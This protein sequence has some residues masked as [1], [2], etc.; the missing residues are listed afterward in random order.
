MINVGK[1]MR[2]DVV[3]ALEGVADID[4]RS[5]SISLL[6]YNRFSYTHLVQMT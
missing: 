5:L 3:K 2:H 4:V 6:A 1:K